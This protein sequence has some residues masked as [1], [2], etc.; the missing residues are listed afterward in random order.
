MAVQMQFEANADVSAEE[1]SFGPEPIARLEVRAQLAR[2]RV[3]EK[4]PGLCPPTQAG[5]E[6][7]AVR[8]LPAFWPPQKMFRC[9]AACPFLSI[10]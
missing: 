7:W 10:Q 5:P 4:L 3:R 1:E 9:L 8:G 6:I 2:R